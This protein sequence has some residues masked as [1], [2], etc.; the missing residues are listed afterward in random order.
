MSTTFNQ[1]HDKIYKVKMTNLLKSEEVFVG[2][3]GILT[4][5]GKGKAQEKH[6]MLT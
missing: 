1:S 4:A 6:G 2:S 3:L 5:C